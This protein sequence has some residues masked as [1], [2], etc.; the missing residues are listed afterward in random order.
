MPLSEGSRSVA[1]SMLPLEVENYAKR[2]DDQK[3]HHYELKGF[4]R[5]RSRTQID[6]DCAYESNQERN[7]RNP[8]RERVA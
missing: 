8:L 1:N 6:D 3:H 7:V 5:S 2:P 4:E